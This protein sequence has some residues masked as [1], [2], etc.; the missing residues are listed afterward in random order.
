MYRVKYVGFVYETT[1]LING[2]KYIGQC[3]FDRINGWENYLG[4]GTYVKRAIKKYGSENFSR[5]ILFLALDQEELDEL[6]ILCIELS[7]AVESDKYYNLKKTAKGGDTFT[8]NPN[9]EKTRELYRKIRSGERNSQYGKPKSE[10]MIQAVKEANSKKIMV[11]GIVYNSIAEGSK[12][13]GIKVTTL[14]FRLKSEYKHNY[15]YLD[16]NGNA[17]SKNI[18]EWKHSA[19]K[20]MVDGIVYNSIYQYAKSSGVSSTWVK[21]R[22][23]SDKYPN[24]EYIS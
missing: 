12:A 21:H 20:I 23:N 5:E 15:L 11:D 3:R 2:M 6:E 4:S 13:L 19:K 10:K 22:L 17:I 1:N 18:R 16:E 24:F 9:K 7:N 8:H 14:C